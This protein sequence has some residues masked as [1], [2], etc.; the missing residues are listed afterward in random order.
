MNALISVRRARIN[1]VMTAKLKGTFIQFRVTDDIKHDLQIVAELRGLTM[2]SLLH[3]LMV[4]TIREEK[5]RE[6]RAFNGHKRKPERRTTTRK[7][8]RVIDQTSSKES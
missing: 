4:K 3:S 7:P 6:P 5:D 1:N 2:S 8:Q